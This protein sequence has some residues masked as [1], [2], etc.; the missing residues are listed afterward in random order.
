MVATR[1]AAAA[2]AA[3]A[4]AAT[5]SAATLALQASQA[6]SFGSQAASWYA[7]K[8]MAVATAKRKSTRVVVAALQLLPQPW[9]E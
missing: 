1:T 2:A 4:T 3:A 6:W 9:Q 7:A 5:S 8:A